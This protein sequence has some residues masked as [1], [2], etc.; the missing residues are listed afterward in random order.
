MQPI[1]AI[2]YLAGFKSEAFEMTGSTSNWIFPLQSNPRTEEGEKKT[3][4]LTN[5]EIN[6]C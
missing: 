6:I 3:K 4:A 2:I 5:Y 1:H